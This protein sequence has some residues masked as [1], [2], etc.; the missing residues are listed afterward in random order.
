MKTF[1]LFIILTLSVSCLHAQQIVWSR[2]AALH[3]NLVQGVTTDV[4]GNAWVYAS[5]HRPFTGGRYYMPQ[6]NLADTVGTTISVFSYN[7]N[8]IARYRWNT[9]FWISDMVHDGAQFFYFCGSFAGTQNLSGVSITCMGM[10]DCVVGK[11]NASG[12]VLWA[13]PMGSR[14]DDR[15]NSIA[16][17]AVTGNVIVAGTV[18]D[19]LFVSGTLTCP[20]AQRNM[21]L[22]EFTSA[23][24]L[25]NY[26]M[27][28][29]L[30]TKD[31]SNEGLEIRADSAGGYRLLYEREGKSWSGD[32][33]NA[34]ADG[35]YLSR[36]DGQLNTTWSSF[37]INS[38]CYYGFYSSNS[39]LSTGGTCYLNSFCSG[40]YGGTENLQ[41]YADASGTVS[42]SQS[43]SDG[44]TAA[45]C[46]GGN[47]LFAIGTYDAVVCP[48]ASNAPGVPAICKYD[49]QNNLV[50]R[51]NF[52]MDVMPRRLTRHSSGR[53]YIAGMLG[54]TVTI[55]KDIVNSGPYNGVLIA[56]DDINCQPVLINN[57]LVSQGHLP[58]CPGDSVILNATPGFGSYQWNNGA[59]TPSLA[60]AQSG[61][62]FVTARQ[63]TGCDPVS[64]PVMVKVSQ[65]DQPQISYVTYYQSTNGY[66]VYGKLP[67]NPSYNTRY[68][69]LYKDGGNGTKP[70]STVTCLNP[71]AAPFVDNS[72]AA[73]SQ[74]PKYYLSVT[75]TC[76]T[77]TPLSDVHI[78]LRL[79]I[80]GTRNVSLVW[81]KYT[82]FI[83][84]RYYVMKGGIQKRIVIDSVP[85]TQQ[86]Y[87][88]PRAALDEYYQVMI[89]MKDGTRVYSNIVATNDLLNGGNGSGSGLF[90][91]LTEEGKADLVTLFPSP[92]SGEVFLQPAAGLSIDDGLVRI[93]NSEGRL[94]EEI[95]VSTGSLSAP[96]SLGR[97]DA[98]GVY[99]ATIKVGGI[100]IVRSFLQE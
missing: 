46:H 11:M 41:L 31:L 96:V 95:A 5:A 63:A 21:L 77:S 91:S 97:R 81:D 93:W 55:G 10:N 89:K 54:D 8:R 36:L 78:P 53:I 59:T 72:A 27:V 56:L 83:Y 76:G 92:S 23:G 66:A 39:C 7:G 68:I 47:A 57:K 48:C 26:R 99:F 79:K 1:T 18:D 15:L 87:I 9:A 58:L 20:S 3:G 74:A 61:T 40:K 90:A 17:N 94:V 80:S 44:Y 2:N 6:F 88:D 62:Y 64:Y 70:V 13:V 22:A 24:Q 29:F 28:D 71:Y 84:N 45:L 38:A 75:D 60:V 85:L 67:A 42:W 33:T 43:R 82:G 25:V 50:G 34:P 32:T 19:S 16:I 37:V 65:P 49:T 51:T 69:R 12:Q 52:P 35:M 30:A 73:A 100:V 14:G 98:P 4:P 86:W